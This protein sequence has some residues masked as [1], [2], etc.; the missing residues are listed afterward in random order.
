MGVR[1]LGG[2]FICFWIVKS[3]W[4]RMG[5]R[6]KDSW[7]IWKRSMREEARE[8]GGAGG[9][10]FADNTSLSGRKGGVKEVGE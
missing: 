8:G 2:W 6:L 5:K 7:E 9:G 1:H 4:D 3:L 10:N